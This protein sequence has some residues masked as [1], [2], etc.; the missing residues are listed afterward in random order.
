KDSISLWCKICENDLL[1]KKMLILFLNKMDILQ[2]TLAV[3]IRMA[4]YVLSCG[5]Q[6]NDIQH[7]T[8][9]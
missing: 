2:A 6:P 1:V 5:D 8:K 9:C 3:G 7:V 4:K